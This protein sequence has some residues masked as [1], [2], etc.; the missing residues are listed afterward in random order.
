MYK[1]ILCI[2]LM[3][4]TSACAGCDICGC[5]PN[6]ISMG[7]QPQF[8]KHFV[9]LRFQQSSFVSK[10]H[11]ISLD[12]TK[13]EST[14]EYFR[15]LQL[16]GRMAIS[17]QIQLLAF[18][19]YKVHYQKQGNSITQLEGLGDISVLGNYM[20]FNTTKDLNK[21]W[22]HALQ[23]GLGIKL[24]NAKSDA[25]KNG[26]MIHTNLQ[27]GSGS[28]DFPLYMNY[29]LRHKQFGG[30]IECQYVRN[31]TN[32]QAF[33]F[34]NRFTHTTRFF[35][36]K[37]KKNW[38]LL[39]QIGYGYETADLDKQRNTIQTYTGGNIV[40][41]NMGIDVYY[42]N[43][44]LNIHVQQPLQQ[45]LGEGFVKSNPRFLSNF[46]YLLNSKKINNEQ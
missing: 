8:N 2:A 45:N 28:F 13:S 17:K 44:S 37:E 5:N 9:G 12:P 11:E 35:Y 27:L 43:V 46:I 19:P 6:M 42:K 33:H 25:I 39:P 7:I 30:M 1:Y 36:W 24:P 38:Q 41:G 10:P 16:W 22:R 20:L 29:T 31:G 15:S 34:G 32:K 40:Y 4:Y 14:R 26:L 23:I 3:L 18:I 21:K